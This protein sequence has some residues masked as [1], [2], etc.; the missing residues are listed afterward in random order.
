VDL[1]YVLCFLA[2]TRQQFQFGTTKLERDFIVEPTVTLL[3]NCQ[4][5]KVRV[6]TRR[7]VLR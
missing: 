4:D 1:V 2:K 7:L 6:G 3:G 5:W